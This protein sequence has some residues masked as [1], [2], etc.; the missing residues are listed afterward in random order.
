[1]DR[2]LAC[3]G[4]AASPGLG[5]AGASGL[6]RRAC[7][8][9]TGSRR[10]E[11][12][13]TV[14]RRGHRHRLHGMHGASGDCGRNA[15]CAISRSSGSRPHAYVKLWKHHAAQSQAD[16]INALAAQRGEPWLAAL[17][18][19]DLVR[20]G[21][22]EGAAAARGGPRDL[23]R[24]WTAGSRRPTGSSGSCAASSTSA[25]RAPP[26]T[27]GSSR[28]ASIPARTSS[29]SSI[30]GSRLRARQARAPDLAPLGDRA[31]GL[32]AEAAA[33]TGLPE[34]IAVAVGNVDAHVTAPAAQAIAPGQ[35]VAIMGTS[36]CHVMN[37]DVLREVPGMCGVVDGGIT[38]GSLRLRGRPERRRRHLRLVRRRRACPQ[39]YATQA[40]ARGVNVHELPDRAGRRAGGRRARP[41]RARLAQRQPLGARRPRA[42]RRRSSGRRWRPRAPEVYRALLEATAFGTRTHRRGASRSAGVPVREFVVA[43]GLL[44]E[45]VAHA[46]LR[47]RHSAAAEPSS[48]PTRARRWAPRST[49]RSP[50]ARTR[51]SR[52]RGARWAG[53]TAT[54]TCPIPVAADGYDELF[55]EYRTPARL[56]R[57]RRPTTCCTALR[58]AQRRSA[59]TGQRGSSHDARSPL[60]FATVVAALHGELV[61]YGLVVWTRGNVSARVPGQRPAGHQAVAASATTS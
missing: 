17:R 1:M 38:R 53:R 40:A 3:S 42:V 8:R 28:T 2:Q 36:T 44:Q 61:R 10:G 50:P 48:A 35:M 30:P 16:R 58:D 55:Q 4:E 39:R 49:P 19:P 9:R 6:P 11:R 34:G 29:P 56:L 21:V 23:C 43:G 5:P 26:A 31:G 15:A 13:L 20:V 33:W 51:T 22:R 25:T 27:R 14:R 7:A 45:R 18:R 24:A 57:P 52:G 54:S 41:R 59:R 32:T 46:D 12:G 47:R 60:T 37:G